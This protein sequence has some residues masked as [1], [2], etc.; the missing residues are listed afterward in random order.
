VTVTRQRAAVSRPEPAVP[1]AVT[2]GV[3]PDVPRLPA[4]GAGPART[5]LLIEI[6]R[7]V[8]EAS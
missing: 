8:T 4:P 1:V 6:P 2:A 7:T 3:A 5:V